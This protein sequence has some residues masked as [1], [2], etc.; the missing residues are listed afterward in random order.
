MCSRLWLAV[1]LMFVVLSGC[2]KAPGPKAVI[3]KVVPVAGTLTYKGQPLEYYQVAFLP[4]DG[5]T[6]AVGV[7]DA[8][9]KFKMGTNK[10]GDGAPPGAS[11]VAI[12][13][14]GPPSTDPPGQEKQIEDPA[15]LPKPK[16]KIPDKYNNPETSGL[17]QDVPKSGFPDLKIDLVE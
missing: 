14:V 12:A 2:G 9:G 5:R 10:S 13:F 1:L 16:I 4:V 11:K 15:L 3:E 17:T 7:T 8:A 6:P